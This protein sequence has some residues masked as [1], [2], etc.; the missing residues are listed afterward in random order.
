MVEEI[1]DNKGIPK[2]KVEAKK[3][4]KERKPVLKSIRDFYEKKYRILLI[5]PFL[6]LVFGLVSVGM[7]YYSEGDF[8]TRDVSLKGGVTLTITTGIDASLPDLKSQ[9]EIEF[10]KNDIEVRSLTQ[11]GSREGIIIV[12]DISQDQADDLVKKAGD[13]LKIGLTEEDYTIEVVSGSLGASFFNEVLR[14]L[15]I[16]FY[17]MSAVVFLFFG[18]NLRQKILA[19]AI[20]AT[21]S[22]L[23]FANNGIATDTIAYCLGIVA[24]YLFIRYSIPSLAVILAAFSD[25]VVTVAIIN[26]IGMKIGTAGI[27]ALL[28]LIGYSVDTDILL[29]TRVLKRKEGTVDERVMGAVVTGMTMTLTAIA[30]VSIALIFTQS[31]VIRQITT[32]LLIGLSIDIIN[33]WIQN[34]GI[35]KLFIE[36]TQKK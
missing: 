24:L 20:L 29:S 34:V 2:E 3:A 26:I 14:A 18:P 27:A 12:A 30:T 5:F 25:I 19:T 4:A 8:V 23:I 10:P 35:L 16:A 32:V 31:D 15:L 7:K 6:L 9:L 28:M 36:H 33:T 11:F 22:V 1:N 13:I 21:G 17:C